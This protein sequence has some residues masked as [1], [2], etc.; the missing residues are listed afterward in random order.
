MDITRLQ[1]TTASNLRF[2]FDTTSNVA[3]ANSYFWVFNV[4]Y[5]SISGLSVN[6]V[7][8]LANTEL[9]ANGVNR[10]L[11]YGN[12]GASWVSLAPG[13][14][15][16]MY[17]TYVE[18]NSTA[19]TLPAGYDQTC[20]ISYV[21]VDSN[22]RIK[23]YTQKDRTIYTYYTAQWASPPIF[24]IQNPEVVDLL[25]NLPPVPVTAQF[26]HTGGGSP[27]IYTL[28]RFWALDL[29]TTFVEG[30]FGGG[31]QMGQGGGGTSAMYL[32]SWVEQQAVLTKTQTASSK[33]YPVSW[34]F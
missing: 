23:E 8:S 3:L 4:D 19:V 21:G 25:F 9:N 27:L 31:Y 20:L 28:G 17:K 33:L 10:G 16:F 26:L 15:T 2:I 5:P 22:T 30:A 13:V 12:T 11:P 14:G 1:V 18:A 6:L 32:S 29:G 34:T 24:Q 7:S